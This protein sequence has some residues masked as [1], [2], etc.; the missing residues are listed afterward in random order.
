M[1]FVFSSSVTQLFRPFHRSFQWLKSAPSRGGAPF[2]IVKQCFAAKNQKIQTNIGDFDLQIVSFSKSLTLFVGGNQGAAT[3][4]FL[5]F[6][7]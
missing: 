7:T 4:K 5:T 6:A 2:N 3:Q 1:I